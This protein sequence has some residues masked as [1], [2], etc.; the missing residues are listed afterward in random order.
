MQLLWHGP[1]EAL[2]TPNPETWQCCSCRIGSRCPHRFKDDSHRLRNLSA[3]IREN[4]VPETL[5]SLP[6]PHSQPFLTSN[7]IISSAQFIGLQEA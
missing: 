5:N 6:R 4:I 7:R 3:A 2:N 1:P